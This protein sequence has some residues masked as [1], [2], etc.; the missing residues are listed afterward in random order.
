[1]SRTIYKYHI[2]T[3]DKMLRLPAPEPLSVGMQGEEM[4]LWAAVTPGATESEVYVKIVG[5]GHPCP[6]EPWKFLGTVFDG[7]YVWHVFWRMVSP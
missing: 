1:M 4:M 5:T 3:P 7:R 2:D 6:A